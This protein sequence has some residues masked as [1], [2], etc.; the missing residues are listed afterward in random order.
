MRVSIVNP[1]FEGPIEAKRF[2]M[3]LNLAYIAGY[4]RKHNVEVNCIDAAALNLSSGQVEEELR[5]YAP[6]I[7][8]VG[9]M[10]DIFPNALEVCRT[11][12]KLG[13]IT[14][15]GGYQ[16]TAFP[17]E[18]MAFKEVD[19]LLTGE[20][21]GVTLSTVKALETGA[22]LTTVKG[23][24]FRK[25]NEIIQTPPAD[26]IEN[27]DTIPQP[28]RDLFPYKLYNSY[29]SI[30]RAQPSTHIMT[31]RG[32]PYGCTFCASK[33]FWKRT[34]RERSANNVVDEIEELVNKYG[35]KEIYIWDDTFNLNVERA[36]AICDEIVRRG[37]K[38]SLRAQARVAPVTERLLRKMLK[39]GF[40]CMYFG[41]ET[42]D[43]DV[44]RSLHKGITLEQVEATFALCNKVG[45]RTFAFFMLNHP[46]ETRE[47]VLRTIE[48]AKS[49]KPDFCNF[50]ISIVYPGTELYQRALQEGRIKRPAPGEIYK[51]D[52]YANKNMSQ[53]EIEELLV[54]A[55]RQF[56]M[57]PWYALQRLVR[58][59]SLTEL[60]INMES[61]FS[62][63]TPHIN[64]FIV[65]NRWISYFKN[66]KD[67]AVEQPK[68]AV[69]AAA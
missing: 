55:N 61:F 53:T 20:G 68:V 42:G 37:I 46:D 14:L 11:A 12:K 47:Q 38:V 9:A 59:R 52:Y 45:M 69:T 58:I 3:P 22:D 34:V 15:L 18:T 65:K 56:Y 62:M 40:W 1:N 57:R 63:L 48:F 64:P 5:K 36:E 31:A 4:L 28:A 39:A 51:P 32:C 41:I 25:G 17:I 44:L 6:Q 66:A 29:S 23:I 60:R 35:Y 49:I 30:A 2:Y 33:S 50:A 67:A 54:H 26:F 24:V 27:L 16:A 7:V 10:S 13:M 19:L 8:V 21:E 43:P